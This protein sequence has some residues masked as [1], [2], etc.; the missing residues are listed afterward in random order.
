[1]FSCVCMCVCVCASVF[2]YWNASP[3]GPFAC[4]YV[5]IHVYVVVCVYV[6]VCKCVLLLECVSS[7]SFCACK[8]THS[9]KENTF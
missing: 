6:C 9:G 4:V 2:S 8:R 3:H 1:M 5:C 7:R